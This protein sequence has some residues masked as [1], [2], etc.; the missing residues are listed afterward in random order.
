MSVEAL[1]EKA[2]LTTNGRLPNG[3]PPVKHEEWLTKY[4]NEIKRALPR[5]MTPDRMARIALTELRRV[6]KLMECNPK[7]FFGAVIQASQLGLEPGGGLGHAYLVPYKQEC[8]LIIGY[9]GM[10][11]L[12]RR[13]G[14]IVS[15]TA[16]VVHEKDEF[17]YAYGLNEKLDHTPF[18]DGDPGRLIYVYAVAR[19]KDGGV[20][21]EV[22]SKADVDKIRQRS[23]SSSSG[24]WVTDYEAMAKKTVIRQIFKYLPVSVEL[25]TAMDLDER[26][27]TDQ[28]QHN[29]LLLTGEAPP[30]ADDGEIIDVPVSESTAMDEWNKDDG[31]PSGQKH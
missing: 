25:R 10:I 7:S 8:Q 6:P 22:M 21:F 30:P 13:S 14:Q 26:A 5:H 20:Q 4:Q 23:K 17:S 15:I 16:R 2:G 11:D 31:P 19:L 29:D 28:P 27:D 12:A 18:A 1:K 3:N 9:R 24:P